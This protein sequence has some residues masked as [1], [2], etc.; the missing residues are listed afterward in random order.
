MAA[1]PNAISAIGVPVS[2]GGGAQG[3]KL[4]GRVLA[5]CRLEQTNH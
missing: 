4:E 5:V 1:I 3:T 2:G